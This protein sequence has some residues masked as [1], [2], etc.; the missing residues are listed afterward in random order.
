[1][2]GSGLCTLSDD[3]SL[4]I[5]L[6]WL[7]THSSAGLLPSTTWHQSLLV[8]SVIT[9]YPSPTCKLTF[10][11]PHPP[12]ALLSPTGLASLL[13][14]L[15]EQDRLLLEQRH[16]GGLAPLAPQL[17]SQ[18]TAVSKPASGLLAAVSLTCHTN[19]RPSSCF[20]S[21]SLSLSHPLPAQ[22][23]ACCLRGSWPCLPVRQTQ[24]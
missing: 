14:Q 4:A 16:K 23:L 20:L 7:T 8:V 12:T 3:S 6:G 17:L 24:P 2:T 13:D 1:M 15:T 11:S 5:L 19:T 10:A 22:P 21:L 9:K 18:G